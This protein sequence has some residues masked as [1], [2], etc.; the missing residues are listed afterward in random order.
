VCQEDRYLKG[1][2]QQVCKEHNISMG[3]LRSG[4][5]RRDLAEI[6]GSISW[7]AVREL[8]Y[9]GADVARYLGVTN[10]CVTRFV[11]PGQKPD[12]DDLIK[13]L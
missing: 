2:A 4:G 5:R 12:V 10:P 9:C 8:G 6:C 7:I 3:E 1:L 13:R 11:A